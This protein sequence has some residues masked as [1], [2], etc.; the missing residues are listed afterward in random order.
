MCSYSADII[1]NM[2]I[3]LLHRSGD[4]TEARRGRSRSMLRLDK[5]R[6]HGKEIIRVLQAE[7]G[8]PHEIQQIRDIF[9]LL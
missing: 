1:K 4:Q 8:P 3:V 6:H 5:G 2:F 9:I 7:Y